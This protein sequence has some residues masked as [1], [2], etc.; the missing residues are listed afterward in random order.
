MI[1]VCSWCREEGA[2]GTL[3]EKPP[4]ENALET[5]GICSLHSSAVMDRWSRQV[6]GD[7]ETPSVQS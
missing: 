2:G 7:P 3:G 4:L 5:H 1:I 6:G